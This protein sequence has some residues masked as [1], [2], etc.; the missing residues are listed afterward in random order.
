MIAVYTDEVKLNIIRV[1]Q[2][3]IWLTVKRC[4][5]SEFRVSQSSIRVT[6]WPI[7]AKMDT[8]LTMVMMNQ[9][10]CLFVC[11]FGTLTSR[12]TFLVCSSL[13]IVSLPRSTITTLPPLKVNKRNKCKSS[14]QLHQ[15][16]TCCS[17]TDKLSSLKG[18]YL[19]ERKCFVSVLES[20]NCLSINNMW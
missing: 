7:N 11:A 18:P 13:L 17:W 20:I 10:F 6:V 19:D 14:A 3:S 9:L 8:K 12:E 4:I 2:T 1:S 5:L 15:S 16:E